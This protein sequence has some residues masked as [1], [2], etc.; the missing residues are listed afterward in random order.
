MP[1]PKEEPTSEA[2]DKDEE[3]KAELES[4]EPPASDDAPPQEPPAP[5]A[6]PFEGRTTEDILTALQTHRKDDLEAFTRGHWE[7]G[8]RRGQGEADRAI[9]E[10]KDRDTYARLSR[11]EKSED[12]D[13]IEEYAKAMR[14]RQTRASYDRGQK[15]HQGPDAKEVVLNALDA[16]MTAVYLPLR[17]HP[18]LKGMTEEQHKELRD[19]WH[20]WAEAEQRAGREA[21]PFT[22]LVVELNNLIIE[23][24]VE[25]GRIADTDKRLA[26]AKEDGRREAYDELGIEYAPAHIEGGGASHGREISKADLDG[27]SLEETR[28]LERAGKLDKVLRGEKVTIAT[29]SKE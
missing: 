24:G 16:A 12:P 7:E 6:D 25:A 13:D 9:Q 18:A 5:P 20:Q 19:K 28:Q 15:L 21:D 2:K 1:K 10:Q 14:D 8:R 4:P 17:Q 29:R 26:D 23:R 22:K 27:L 11:L 3:P